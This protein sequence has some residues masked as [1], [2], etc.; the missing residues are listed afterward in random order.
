[1]TLP[2][3]LFIQFVEQ[4]IKKGLVFNTTRTLDGEHYLDQTY[5]IQII[6]KH[7]EAEGKISV[8]ALASLLNVEQH[9]ITRLIQHISSDNKTWSFI[10][11]FVFTLAFIKEAAR[12]VQQEID[13]KGIMSII[14]QSQSMKLPYSLLK[15]ILQDMDGYIQYSLLP[16]I[17]MTKDYVNENKSRIKVALEAVEEPLYLFK[18]QKSLNIPEDMFYLWVDQVIKEHND[19]GTIRGKRSRALFE[20]KG[21]KE[22]QMNLIKSIFDS[23]GFISF[24]TIGNLYSFTDPLELIQDNSDSYYVLNSC[25]IKTHIKENAKDMIRSTTNYCDVNVS[26]LALQYALLTI[27]Q[28]A[29]PSSLTLGDVNQVIDLC[30]QELASTKKMITLEGG[31]V[32]SLDYVKS[33]V[34]SSRHYLNKLAS[35]IKQ[36]DSKQ[37][38]GLQASDMVKALE[39][40]GCPYN[41]SEKILPFIRKTLVQQFTEMMQTPYVIQSRMEG[42][43]WVMKQR[44]REYRTLVG[45]RNS[46]Y[47]NYK[48]ISLFEE[49]LY[50]LVLYVILDQS[51]CQAEVE[52]STSL[53]ISAEDITK[54]NIMDTKQQKCVVAYF[55]RENDHRYDKTSVLE[56]EEL[57]KKK[58][59][60]TFVTL[61]LK[62]DHQQLF[63]ETPLIDNDNDKSQANK[64]VFHQL[65]KQLD[66]T[67]IS[68]ETAPQILHL[69]SLLLFLKHYQLPLYVSGKFVPVILQQLDHCLSS[70]ERALVNKAHDS[71]IN[72][73]RQAHLKDYQQLTTLGLDC[74]PPV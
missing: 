7:V 20:P 73:Q 62:Q 24:D 40:V 1:M 38:K 61:F 33:L 71:I 54:Q 29:L 65:Y 60:K 28:D 58:K 67:T 52:Q 18:V 59:L 4:G 57:L 8:E 3:S 48:A 37:V 12:Q 69:V 43:S 19:I 45:L 30:V 22:Q 17:I 41:I 9:I 2:H 74:P 42:D 55:I 16:D 63:K 32:I 44:E 39:S 10:D 66:Q 25:V 50:H 34:E 14:S 49:F 27:S 5:C 56:V 35:R 21:Y 46:I 36:K 64:T 15:S 23:N 11:D 68:E 72:N 6:T 70:E 13:K 47:F 53:C 51:Y 31:Y 26:L